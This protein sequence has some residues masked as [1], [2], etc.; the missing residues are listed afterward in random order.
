MIVIFCIFNS[1]DLR[2]FSVGNKMATVGNHFATKS[3]KENN[4][5]HCDYFTSNKYDFKKHLSTVK[6]KFA[7]LATNRQPLATNLAIFGDLSQEHLCKQTVDTRSHVCDDCGRRYKDKSGLWKHKKKCIVKP[8]ETIQSC[9]NNMQLIIKPTADMNDDIKFDN[10]ELIK[11]LMR[12]NQEFKSMLVDQNN[13]LMDLAKEG[14]YITNN[15]TTNNNFN[16]HFFLNE[17]CKDALNIMDFV[18]SLQLQLN[19]LETTGRLGYVEGI[20]KIFIKGLQDLDVCKRPIHC[21]DLKRETIY[22][23]D[24][25]MWEKDDEKQKMKFAIKHVAH[26]NV[27]KIPEWQ[28]ENPEYCDAES[29]VNEEYLKIVSH[30]MGGFTEEEDD[31]NMNKIIRNIS[32]KVVIDKSG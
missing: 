15:N 26:K 4:C 28:K 30:A 17:K 5:P 12:Q 9:E 31:D 3:R 23:K 29:K 8:N 10:N 13:K 20:T 32:K 21:S 27:M 16:L 14:K 19:D 18:K 1:K 25:D 22:V 24:Q 7:I 11:E 6:H 2:I